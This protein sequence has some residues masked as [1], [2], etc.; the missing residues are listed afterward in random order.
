MV[1]WPAVTALGFL[2]LLGIVI[3]LG[4]SSTARYEF[5]RNRVHELRPQAARSKAGKHPA[6]RRAATAGAADAAGS[7]SAAADQPARPGAAVGL[8]SSP[9]GGETPAGGPAGGAA[10]GWWLLA[11]PGGDLE[12]GQ[13]LAGPFADRVDADWAALSAELPAFAVYGVRRPGGELARRPSPHDRAWLVELGD[14]LDRLPEDWDPLLSDTD[15]LTTLVVEVA[16]ALAEAGLP[17][18][19]CREGGAAA[20]SGGVCLTPAPDATGILVSWRQHDRMSL[21]QVRGAAADAAVQRTM[22]AAV[23]AI[24]AELAFAVEPFGDTGC[25][26]VTVPEG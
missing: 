15:E 7:G 25:S 18:H 14:Q 8:A 23:A 24:L 5:D 12:P 3:A 2:A 13:V 6:G 1:L 20:P 9:A 10:P 26:I 22:N 11:D 17:L 19:D 4:I 21:H 16:A